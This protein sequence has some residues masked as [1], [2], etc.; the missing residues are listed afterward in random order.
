MKAVEHKTVS[1]TLNELH[2]GL[3]RQ[4]RALTKGLLEHRIISNEIHVHEE[5]SKA[6]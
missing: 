6:N 3:N 2:I 4:G 1:M 5:K